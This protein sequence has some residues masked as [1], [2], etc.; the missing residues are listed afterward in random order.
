MTAMNEMRVP[1][2]RCETFLLD[3][4]LV[5]LGQDASFCPECNAIWLETDEI[6]LNTLRDYWTFMEG[7]GRSSGN[8]N[9]LMIRGFR[10]R[11]LEDRM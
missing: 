3:V 5:Y 11:K 8:P 10:H 2:A 7:H 6:A 1:C 4:R 9:E